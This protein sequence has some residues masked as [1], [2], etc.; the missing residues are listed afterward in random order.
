MPISRFQRSSCLV[1]I[2]LYS[3]HQ[4]MFIC[5]NPSVIRMMRSN[6]CTG[7]LVRKPYCTYRCN[8]RNSVSRIS[9]E[10][11]LRCRNQ[12]DSMLLF[13]SESKSEI[14]PRSIRM[15][16]ESKSEICGSADVDEFLV[17]DEFGDSFI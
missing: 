12:I 4:R 1:R 3:D 7:S 13:S 14:L 17:R 16:S 10:S 9:S 2:P 6:V 15:S 11:E 8:V 5:T